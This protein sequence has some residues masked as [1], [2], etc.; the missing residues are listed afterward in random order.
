[1]FVAFR[2]GLLFYKQFA[3]VAQVLNLIFIVAYLFWD[4]DSAVLS[5]NILLKLT[6]WTGLYFFYNS[7][8][9]KRY[10][11]YYNLGCTKAI[12]WTQCLVWDA[13]SLFLC[14]LIANNVF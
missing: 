13:L 9:N 6:L 12:L 4:K 2:P 3:F 14:T 1:M 10:L 8:L 11:F 7:Y 5:N